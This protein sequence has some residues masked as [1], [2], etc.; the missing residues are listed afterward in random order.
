M[1]ALRDITLEGN[2]ECHTIQ[3]SLIQLE[4]T[5]SKGLAKAVFPCCHDQAPRGMGNIVDARARSLLN[6]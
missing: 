5:L 1:D 2:M 6:D 3:N 4:V